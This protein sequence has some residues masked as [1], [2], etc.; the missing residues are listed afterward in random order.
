MTWDPLES[1]GADQRRLLSEY[2]T[3]LREINQHINLISREDER[4]LFEHHILHSLAL[5]RRRFPA[6]TSVIDWGT[7]GGLPAI[8]LAIAFPGVRFVAVDAVSKKVRAVRTMARRLGLENLETWE[9]RAES[10]FPV[11]EAAYSVSRATATLADLWGWHARAAAAMRLDDH[12]RPERR[13]PLRLG[14]RGSPERLSLDD[15]WKPGLVCLKGGD[16]SKE[17]EDLTKASP[18]LDVAQHPLD[19]FIGAP[20]FR[21]KYIVEVHDPAAPQG[22]RSDRT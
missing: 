8:P 13:P 3:L 16:L 11:G 22:S 5:T 14:A 19:E 1:L 7:G 2:E 17:I 18:N 10:Y 12:A 4:Q 20:Y 21:E 9:G 6:G 15:C